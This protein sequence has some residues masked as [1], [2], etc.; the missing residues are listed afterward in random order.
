MRTPLSRRSGD[1]QDGGPNTSR[2]DDLSVGEFSAVCLDEEWTKHQ[3]HSDAAPELKQRSY[4]RRPDSGI[5]K[6]TNLMI[7]GNRIH[8]ETNGATYGSAC[9]KCSLRGSATV[10]LAPRSAVLG[11]DQGLFRAAGREL[12]AGRLLL[13]QA[14]PVDQA[15]VRDQCLWQVS[16]AVFARFIS[17]QF[18]Q[19]YIVV[20]LVISDMASICETWPWHVSHFTPD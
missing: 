7:R 8:E 17:W 10:V 3:R 15:S 4:Q 12:A 2:T 9:Q 18:R 11:D 19:L 1:C 13:E 16:Q 6:T 20:T 5:V 14:K